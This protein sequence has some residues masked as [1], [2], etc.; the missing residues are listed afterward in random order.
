M[1]GSEQGSAEANQL[2]HK[3]TNIMEATHKKQERKEEMKLKKEK[4]W[5]GKWKK[6]K[7]KW[8]VR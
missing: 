4:R 1:P 2:S 8:L 6:L 3:S 5:M 7:D